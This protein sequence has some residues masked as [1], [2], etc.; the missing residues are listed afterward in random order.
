[1]LACKACGGFPAQ[2]GDQ[3]LSCC[4]LTTL[5]GFNISREPVTSGGLRVHWEYARKHRE[6][7]WSEYAA[8]RA[9]FARRGGR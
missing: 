3:L 2:V 4:Y 5:R 1:M 8:M 9:V 6:A 7:K